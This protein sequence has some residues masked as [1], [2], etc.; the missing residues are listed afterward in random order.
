LSDEYKPMWQELP[1]PSEEDKRLFEEWV[2]RQEKEKQREQKE[3]KTR[4]IVIEI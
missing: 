3:E 1:L 2:E 4:V